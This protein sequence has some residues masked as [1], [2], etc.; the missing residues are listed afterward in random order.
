MAYGVQDCFW[1]SL[2]PTSLTNYYVQLFAVLEFEVE[3]T[4]LV[5]ML[6]QERL[7]LW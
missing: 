7:L 4:W 6:E 2:H 1:T 5:F 3:E